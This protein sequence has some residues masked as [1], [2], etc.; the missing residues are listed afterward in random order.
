MFFILVLAFDITARQE[1]FGQLIFYLNVP[2]ILEDYFVTDVQKKMLL[3]SFHGPPGCGKSHAAKIIAEHL[4]EEG[5]QAKC[6]RL[7]Y[8]IRDFPDEKEKEKYSVSVRF[9]KF[10]YYFS[11][12]I[13]P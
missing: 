1:L 3:M 13:M 7:F 2:K 11:N 6:V 12:F 5:L 10:S 4:F 8:G 9:E